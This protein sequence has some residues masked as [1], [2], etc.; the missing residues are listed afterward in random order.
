M[1]RKHLLLAATAAFLLAHVPLLHAADATTAAEDARSALAR[2][3]SIS[4]DKNVLDNGGTV[5]VTGKAAPG[6]PVFLEVFNENRV[7]GSYFDNKP[8]KE[9]KIPYKLYLAKDIPAFYRIHL[10]SFTQPVIDK[11]KKEGKGWSYLAALKDTGGELAYREPATRGIDGY[12][13]SMSATMSGSRGD[14]LPALDGKDRARRSMQIVKARFR[15]IEKLLVANIDLKEDGSFTAQV[16]IPDGAPPGKYFITAATD[17]N[18]QSLPVTMENRIAFPMRY[19]SNA[20]TSLN[21]VY[22]F[23]I[24]LAL[25]T[26]G[27]LMGAGG[28][29]IINPIL[30]MFF[31]LPHNVVAGTVTPTVLFSQA[32]GVANYSRI[33]F[34]SWKVGIAMGL[35]TLAGAFIGPIL[36]QMITLDDF[37]FVFGWILFF[38]AALMFWQTTPG[39]I[40]KN[41]KEQAILKEFQ[42]RAEA[43]ARNKDAGVLAKV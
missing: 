28:G 7:S 3:P 21:I 18:A 33:K 36:T 4:I 31:P 35:A 1:S 22:P 32:S 5:T 12:Q 19:M 8:D 38:L 34:I 20:G 41:K 43:A 26:F 30:L 29:F 6:M 40:A 14:P 9:G 23:L 2:A 17:K 25:A 27:V 24:T 13:A 39:Y 16:K 37:K 15:S 42:K 11:Y 10:P